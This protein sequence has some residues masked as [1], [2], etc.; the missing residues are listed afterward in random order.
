VS[1]E[2]GPRTIP[3]LAAILQAKGMLAKVRVLDV[4]CMDDHRL[5]Q[6]LNIPGRGRFAL[7][8][9]RA[10]RWYLLLST[11]AIRP[12][13]SRRGP[14]V[15]ACT[16]RA[17]PAEPSHSPIARKGQWGQV[18]GEY[19]ATLRLCRPCVRQLYGTLATLS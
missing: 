13:S 9:D 19:P 17:G 4:V 14:P 2:V 18:A 7:G 6:V 8:I 12:A 5:V 15:Y 1:V 11:P 3:E 16:P 10:K